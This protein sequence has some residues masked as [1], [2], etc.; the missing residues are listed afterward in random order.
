M[1]EKFTF[2]LNQIENYYRAASRDFN[3]LRKGKH[4][5]EIV[6]FFSYNVVIK[7][8][9]AVC[10]KEGLRI[11]SKTGHHIALISKLAEILDDEEVVEMAGMMRMK[12]NK[13]LYSGGLPISRKEAN[14]YFNFCKDLLKKAEEFLFQNKL[15]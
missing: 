13:D 7:I 12:R 9:I 2:S 1:F 5:P 15:F 10:A 14:F 8:S 6:F 3:I 11:K 4:E